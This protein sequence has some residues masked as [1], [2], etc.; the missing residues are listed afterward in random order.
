MMCEYLSEDF[1]A[2]TLFDVDLQWFA[3]EDEGR[4]EDPS[5]HKLKKAREEGRVAKSQEIS[6]A[7]VMLFPSIAIIILAPWLFNNFIEILLFYFYRSTTAEL[8]GQLVYGFYYYLIRMVTPIAV[9]ALVAGIVANLVQ[10][11]GFIFSTKPL[12]PKFS[13]IIPKFGEYFKKTMFSFEGVF[14]IFKSILK[15]VIIFM[16]SFFIIRSEFPQLLSLLNT[17]LWLGITHIAGITAKILIIAAIIFLVI[18]IPDYLVQRRQFIESMK[19]TKQEVKEEFKTMEGD[20]LVKGRL[21]QFMRE[22]LQNSI[23]ENVAKADV[24]I[25]NPTHFAIAVLYDREV[26][27]GPMVTAKGQDEL[28]QQIKRLAQE[29]DVPMIENRPLAR[30]LYAQVE[31]GD[32]IPE[33]YYTV[34]ATILGKVY[35]MKGKK[36]A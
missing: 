22:L 1:E 16:V 13:K 9:T 10:N 7:L 5:E 4:T 12:E 19:M 27:Q 25:T 23:R 21:K 11:K 28:A 29:N 14:N 20:P 6:G 18:A 35:A 34:L 32:I 26:M 2:Y 33:E 24:I 15:V 8:N 3:A 17:S 30:A 36:I 31:I